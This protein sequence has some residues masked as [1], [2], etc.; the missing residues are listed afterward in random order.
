LELVIFATVMVMWCTTYQ[1]LMH[2][3][4]NTEAWCLFDL[5][6]KVMLNAA[7]FKERPYTR[8][9]TFNLMRCFS[10]E[11]IMYT[12]YEKM[13]PVPVMLFH[14]TVIAFFT[15]IVQENCTRKAFK[16]NADAW[17]ALKIFY[18]VSYGIIILNFITTVEEHYKSNITRTMWLFICFNGGYFM[19]DFTEDFLFNDLGTW[20]GFYHN[21]DYFVLNCTVFLSS[22]FMNHCWI[23]WNHPRGAIRHESGIAF[24]ISHYQMPLV[25]PHTHFQ[26]SAAEDEHWIIVCMSNM[27]YAYFTLWYSVAW[28][29]QIKKGKPKKVSPE[30]LKQAVQN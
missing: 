30:L 27:V 5:L 10:I 18:M 17:I 9:L 29:N 8:N 1:K 16:R 23:K 11:F 28:K 12:T 24:S 25:W 26:N 2:K 7:A 21:R 4:Y 13:S 19:G 3:I 14:A 15:W 6:M 22:Y 20:G